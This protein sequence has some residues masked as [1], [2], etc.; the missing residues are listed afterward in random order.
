MGQACSVEARV[1]IA[2]YLDEKSGLLRSQLTEFRA[3]SG[4]GLEKV[5]DLFHKA[6]GGL[7]KC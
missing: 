4:E 6:V 1:E 5:F 7:S 3:E 2:H